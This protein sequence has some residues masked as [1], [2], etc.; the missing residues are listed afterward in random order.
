[1]SRVSTPCTFERLDDVDDDEMDRYST[2]SLKRMGSSDG[3]VLGAIGFTGVYVIVTSFLFY[4]S[5]FRQ[6]ESFEHESRSL[7]IVATHVP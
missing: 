2:I 7:Q 3:V 5:Q 6:R 1:M 4:E